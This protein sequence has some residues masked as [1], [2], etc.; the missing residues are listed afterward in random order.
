[1]K[2]MRYRLL[3][4]IR[5]SLNPRNSV[6]GG[7]YLV[8]STRLETTRGGHL[9]NNFD[10]DNLQWIRAIASPISGATEMWTILL[11]VLVS[12]FRGMVLATTTSSRSEFVMRLL[13]GPEKTPCDGNAKTRLA[14]ALF[15]FCAA[16]HS[17][18]AVSIMSSTSM[19][20][21]PST[22]PTKSI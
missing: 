10:T 9:S 5:T 22:S 12:S 14:P 11:F 17:V 13:A 18:P 19:Q 15:S 20:S 7:L 2:N 4:T 21:L 1:M 3:H 8:L 6:D 16:L